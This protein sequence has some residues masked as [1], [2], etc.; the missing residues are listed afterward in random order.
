MVVRSVYRDTVRNQ[1]GGSQ[2]SGGRATHPTWGF[3]QSLV[4]NG[5]LVFNVDVG[6]SWGHGKVSRD[7]LD[8]CGSID[9]DD[10]ESGVRHLVSLGYADP[11]RVGIWSLSYGGLMTTMS[12]FTKPGFYAAGVAGAP[13]TNVWHAYPE[14]MRVMAELTGDDYPARYERQSSLFQAAGLEDPMM[15]IHGTKDVVVLYADSIAHAEMLMAHNKMFE[16][17]TLPGAPHPGADESVEM[18]RHAFKRTF[19]FFV[20]HLK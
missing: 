12:L 10:I 20:R 19:E 17:V 8:E 9:I 1:W 16:L 3:D 6:G 5:Y 7:G 2:N 14:Q 18:T 15:I 13:A 4:A 11:E